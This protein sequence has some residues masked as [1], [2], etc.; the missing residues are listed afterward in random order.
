M[1]S[2]LSFCPWKRRSKKDGRG[3]SLRHSRH[4]VTRV[5][6][7]M[8]MTDLSS[9]KAG[10]YASASP[11]LCLCATCVVRAATPVATAARSWLLTCLAHAATPLVGGVQEEY[12]TINVNRIRMLRSSSSCHD[13]VGLL[14]LNGLRHWKLR[15]SQLL[16]GTSSSDLQNRATLALLYILF[17][18]TS[19]PGLF[20]RNLCWR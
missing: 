20:R 5:T 19:R 4:S 10:I 17:Y 11:L 2:P 13:D 7:L 8:S 15:Y 16:K 14:L 18:S 12:K 3:L 1:F 6:W 9:D